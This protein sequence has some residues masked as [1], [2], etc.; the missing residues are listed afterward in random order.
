[1]SINSREGVEIIWIILLGTRCFIDHDPVPRL[2]TMVKVSKPPG[3]LEGAEKTKGEKLP[4]SPK[5]STWLLL[6]LLQSSVL[7]QRMPKRGLCHH[8]RE[9][10]VGKKEWVLSSSLPNK[11]LSGLQY[12]DIMG[13]WSAPFYLAADLWGMQANFSCINYIKLKLSRIMPANIL[14]PRGAGK[15]RKA[16][17]LLVLKFVP[18]HAL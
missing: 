4:C 17:F 10:Q 16:Y 18:L 7:D 2:S 11:A 1:M 6:L 14:S 12:L 5:W 13:E 8:L 15:G 3:R 9:I